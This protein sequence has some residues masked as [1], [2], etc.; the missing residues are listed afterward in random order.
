MSEFPGDLVIRIPGFHCLA[1]I[2]YLVRE[3]RFHKLNGM[4]FQNS[5]NSIE[6]T[7][8]EQNTISTFMKLTCSLEI[9]NVIR[10]GRNV[11]MH[12][13]LQTSN[14][15]IW[16]ILVINIVYVYV[17]DGGYQKSLFLVY[18]FSV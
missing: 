5:K 10:N 14:R 2:Q 9:D 3:L 11:E 4:A 18:S 13:T 8:T 6:W 1:C 15:R 7:N 17:C 16:P 12:S